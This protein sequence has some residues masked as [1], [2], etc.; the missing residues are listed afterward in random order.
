MGLLMINISCDGEMIKKA[1]W[2]VKTEL[3]LN[4]DGRIQRIKV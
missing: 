2:N 3:K 4:D 1:G